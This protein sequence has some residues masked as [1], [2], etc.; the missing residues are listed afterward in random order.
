MLLYVGFWQTLCAQHVCFARRQ[1]S[2]RAMQLDV[3]RLI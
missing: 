3:G 1:A 2:M